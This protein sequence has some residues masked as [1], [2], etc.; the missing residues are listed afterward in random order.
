MAFGFLLILVSMT[1]HAAGLPVVDVYKSP[2]CECCKYWI[3]HLE[4]HGFPV[5]S[6][7]TDEVVRHKY[8]LG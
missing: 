3:Q 6:V 5:R 4:E 7:N 8:R 2:S 1:L